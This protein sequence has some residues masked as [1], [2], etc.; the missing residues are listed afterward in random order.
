MRKAPLLVLSMGLVIT[1]TNASYAGD[2]AKGTGRVL[3]AERVVGEA[4]H[5]KFT[6][7]QL[8]K[9]HAIR[10]KYGDA[11]AAR[12]LELHKLHRQIAEGL[13][14]TTVDK[15]ALLTLQKKVNDLESQANTERLQMMVEVHEILTP[16][17]RQEMHRHMLQAEEHMPPGPMMMHHAGGFAIGMPPGGI[18]GPGFPP[19][20]PPPV[21]VF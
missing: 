4:P 6:D 16:E 1:I 8:E 13:A 21:C 12:M 5:P 3:V 2:D 20:P 15:D 10:A 14:Q 7:D 9:M 18:A 11:G 17:Q 19:G